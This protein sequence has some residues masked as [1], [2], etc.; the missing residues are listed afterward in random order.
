MHFVNITS[1]LPKVSLLSC[2][3]AQWVPSGKSHIFRGW[4]WIS[5]IF[6]SGQSVKSPIFLVLLTRKMKLHEVMGQLGGC[7]WWISSSFC[8]TVQF[9]M[10]WTDFLAREH[11][12]ESTG[13]CSVLITQGPCS[14]PCDEFHSAGVSRKWESCLGVGGVGCISLIGQ[15]TYPMWEGSWGLIQGTWLFQGETPNQKDP[16][17]LVVGGAIMMRRYSGF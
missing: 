1:N 7:S 16:K 11:L 4:E 2:C 6:F 10:L 8:M 3:F 12:L 14:I 5:S 17:T 15:D 13:P 9:L